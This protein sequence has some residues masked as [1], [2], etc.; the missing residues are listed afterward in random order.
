M[1]C[2]TNDTY[3][4]ISGNEVLNNTNSLSK[5]EFYELFLKADDETVQLIEHLLT[6]SILL[7]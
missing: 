4:Q 5:E 2:A 7:P 3:N 1:A 6:G